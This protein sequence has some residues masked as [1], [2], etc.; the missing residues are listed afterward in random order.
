MAFNPDAPHFSP[1]QLSALALQAMPICDT[2]LSDMPTRADHLGENWT[3]VAFLS[4][5]R[6]E[7]PQCVLFRDDQHNF[8]LVI[9]GCGGFRDFQLYA[10]GSWNDTLSSKI[11]GRFNSYAM[12]WAN[13]VDNWLANSGFPLYRSMTI[14]GHS[15]GGAVGSILGRFLQG[16]EI[17]QR[18]Q[19]FSMGA[20][21]FCD[22]AGARACSNVYTVRLMNFGDPTPLVPPRFADAPQV[23]LLMSAEQRRR[24]LQLVHVEGGVAFIWGS[25]IER[26]TW[27]V[28]VVTPLTISLPT[29]WELFSSANIV[30]HSV[31]AYSAQLTSLI[32]LD[33]RHN[34]VP[35]EVEPYSRGD[36]RH[37]D[38][39]AVE[40]QVEQLHRQTILLGTRVPQSRANRLVSIRRARGKYSVYVREVRVYSATSKR[41]AIG[42][43]NALRAMGK[44]YLQNPALFVDPTSIMSAF[45]TQA[46]LNQE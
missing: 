46:Q 23:Y 15:L 20:P 43:A 12:A 41:D 44:Q 31:S 6:G 27:P 24:W 19:H 14:V 38:L 22:D 35:V 13:Q 3:P 40:H 11:P 36:V 26:S 1:E 34:A 39:L 4:Y 25:R 9:A 37:S 29:V 30:N 17:A 32:G 45:G 2:M 33:R 10:E 16:T 28:G 42:V 21:L 7:R 5:V 8:V 18:V